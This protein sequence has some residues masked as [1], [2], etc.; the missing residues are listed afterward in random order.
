MSRKFALSCVLGLVACTSVSVQQLSDQ[1]LVTQMGIDAVLTD[2]A[3]FIGDRRVTIDVQ[4]FP[5]AGRLEL[6]ELVGLPTARK[7]DIFRC[8][9]NDPALCE[10]R[11][12]DFMVVIHGVDATTEKATIEFEFIGE[13][14]TNV[15]SPVW[16]KGTRV[17]LKRGPD[18]WA[19]VEVRKTWET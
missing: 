11:G 1:V 17:S 19:V 14:P 16:T 5:A 15:V 18:G 7:Q 12:T 2:N 4:A 13:E 6:T 3:R 10:L 9:N 8:E